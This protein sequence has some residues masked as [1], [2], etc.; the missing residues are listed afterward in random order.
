M[1][2]RQESAVSQGFVASYLFA[3]STG[4][5]YSSTVPKEKLDAARNVVTNAYPQVI[6][7]L[8]DEAMMRG[9]H[10]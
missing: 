1:S 8:L 5:V 4:G 9:A 7:I 6:G 2:E 10:Q 3:V